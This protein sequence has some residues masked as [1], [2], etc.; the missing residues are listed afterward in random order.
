MRFNIGSAETEYISYS[1]TAKYSLG[2]VSFKITDYRH[3]LDLISALQIIPFYSRFTRRLDR[4]NI[5]AANN[6]AIPVARVKWANRFKI[7]AWSY[8]L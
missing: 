2:H 8:P 7:I 3:I 1:F 4:Y 6:G 5:C